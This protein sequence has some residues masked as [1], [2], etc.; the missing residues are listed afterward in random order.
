MMKILV[1]DPLDEQG[2]KM[3]EAVEGVTAEVKTGLK[4]GETIVTQKIEP[5][6]PSS[7]GAFGG[8]MGRMGGFR[9]GGGGGRR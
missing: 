5:A 6:P 1:A 7:G 8:G 9:G 2:L 4:E 3:I